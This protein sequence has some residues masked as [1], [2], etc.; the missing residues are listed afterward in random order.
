MAQGSNQN[1]PI[2]V[3]PGDT[4]PA[5]VVPARPGYAI[6]VMGYVLTCAQLGASWPDGGTASVQW[7]DDSTSPANPLSGPMPIRPSLPLVAPVAPQTGEDLG[8]YFQTASGANLLLLAAGAPITG[9]CTF[10]Y[11]AS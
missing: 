8:G 2:D 11:I 7:Q 5:I 10:C 6:R 1:V 3:E 4:S 9:H